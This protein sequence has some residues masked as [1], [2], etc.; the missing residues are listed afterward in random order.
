M[1]E[2][3]QPLDVLAGGDQQASLMFTF[4][5]RL[6]LNLRRPCRSLASANRGSTH[7]LLLRKA[8]S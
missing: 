5:S 8:F 3:E 6:S 1:P 2:G 4:S 7:T